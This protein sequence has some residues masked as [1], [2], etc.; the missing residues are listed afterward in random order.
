[1]IGT[2]PLSLSL[3]KKMDSFA[4]QEQGREG[5]AHGVLIAFIKHYEV[6]H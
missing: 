3:N 1:M 4:A 5:D 6:R 2:A